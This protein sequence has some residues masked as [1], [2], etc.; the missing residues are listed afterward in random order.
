M[1]ATRRRTDPRPPR[2]RLA[3]LTREE[4]QVLFQLRLSREVS[5][6]CDSF[7][8]GRGIPPG[9]MAGEYPGAAFGRHLS[10]PRANQTAPSKGEGCVKTSTRSG[11]GSRPQA[12]SHEPRINKKRGT[13][14][15]K[16]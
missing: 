2:D 4:R 13:Q 16:E 14:L 3:E 8:R 1:T 15:G 6:A 5:A 7:L 11:K 12:F 9:T 10:R